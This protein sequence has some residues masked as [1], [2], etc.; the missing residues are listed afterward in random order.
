MRFTTLIVATAAALLLAG[1]T[2]APAAT[3]G[4]AGI[5]PAVAAP[6]TLTVSAV[7]Q[8][9]PPQVKVEISSSESKTVW[10]TQPVWLAIGGL[11]LLVII[12]LVVMAARGGRS[13]TTVVK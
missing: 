3:T 1:T 7:Q 11:A 10:Y 9:Q 4:S 2:S 5:G 6:M 12:L 13:N 8:A